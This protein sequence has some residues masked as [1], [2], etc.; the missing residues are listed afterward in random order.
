MIFSIKSEI[1]GLYLDS[2]VYYSVT[3]NLQNVV[4]VSLDANYVYWSDIQ[5]GNEA[6]IR[7][8][9]DGSK[10]EVIV[11]TGGLYTLSR[12]NNY[13]YYINVH[14]CFIFKV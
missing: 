2:E 12:Y 5:D 7:S 10:Q 13:I 8:L 6:I 4:A 14:L 11:T 9:E 1:H 3:Q